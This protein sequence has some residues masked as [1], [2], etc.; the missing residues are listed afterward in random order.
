MPDHKRGFTQRDEGY[1]VSNPALASAYRDA[2]KFPPYEFDHETQRFLIEVAID[3]CARR[4]WKL[5][6]ASAER[7]H[8]HD[9]VS[10][11]DGTRWAAVRGKIKNIMSLELSKRSG[12]VGRR[13]FVEE[14]SRKR[15]ERDAHF[16]Y[17]K[18]TYLPDHS[19]WCYDDARGW[20]P[21]RGT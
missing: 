6:G 17:L 15:V 11:R 13:W 12:E 10:W 3:V 4:G 20:R 18:E 8:L 2:A 21:P 16:D 7:T 5:H 9:L 14:A 1:Q 19:G